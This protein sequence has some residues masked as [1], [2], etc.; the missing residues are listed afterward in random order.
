MEFTSCSLDHS[1]GRKLAQPL[2][3]NQD[4]LIVLSPSSVCITSLVEFLDFVGDTSASHISILFDIFHLIY[5]AI[6]RSS[7]RTTTIHSFVLRMGLNLTCIFKTSN[8][9]NTVNNHI[10]QF[11]FRISLT[12][13]H[14]EAILFSL[15]SDF[16]PW[17]HTELVT[18]GTNCIGHC[19][20]FYTCHVS[21]CL[22]ARLTSRLCRSWDCSV[23]SNQIANTNRSRGIHKLLDIWTTCLFKLLATAALILIHIN[24]FIILTVSLRKN[25]AN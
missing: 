22:T 2:R 13:N 19:N 18:L 15:S 5:L 6:Y 17:N 4:R 24:I 16:L 3:F 9:T 14:P 12:W 20:L 8:C 23:L 1:M 25:S 11:K 21:S 7:I 10:F